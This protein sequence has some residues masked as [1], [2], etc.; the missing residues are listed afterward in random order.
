MVISVQ[1]KEGGGGK[2][3]FFFFFSFK[4]Q[5]PVGKIRI[6]YQQQLITSWL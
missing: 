4:A 6:K 2:P 5:K 1:G 3:N